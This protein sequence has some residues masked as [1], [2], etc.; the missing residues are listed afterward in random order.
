MIEIKSVYENKHK[1]IID[2][3]KNKLFITYNLK[4]IIIF[5]KHIKTPPWMT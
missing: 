2:K 4:K 5:V 3:E 1:L